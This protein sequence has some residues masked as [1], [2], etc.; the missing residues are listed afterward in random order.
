[1]FEGGLKARRP[2]RL[3]RKIANG[4]GLPDFCLAGPGAG[5]DSRA[6]GE[7]RQRPWAMTVFRLLVVVAWGVIVIRANASSDTDST[8]AAGSA[9]TASFVAGVLVGRWWLLLVPV[10]PGLLSILWLAIAA[11]P[12]D[13]ADLSKFGA[14]VITGLFILMVTAPAALGVGVRR[15]SERGDGRRHHAGPA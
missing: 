14:V 11:D 6:V 5:V 13:Y 1:M 2:R 8:L 10:T 7:S 3:R 12:E 15:I 4:R 9:V